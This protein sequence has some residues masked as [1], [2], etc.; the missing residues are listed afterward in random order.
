[1]R[2]RQLTLT[3]VLLA[4]LFAS[5]V[6]AQCEVDQVFPTIVAGPDGKF[7]QS[8]A[9][10]DDTA[11]VGAPFD[12]SPGV[13]T[14]SVA[15]FERLT[16]AGWTPADL[17]V[18]ADL[19]P[20]DNFGFAVAL[21]DNLAAVGSWSEDQLGTDAGAVYIFE[22]VAGSW[23][24]TVKLFA[25]DTG[26]GSRFG[27]SV[28]LEG[29]TLLVGSPGAVGA[30]L[31]PS[32]GS[33][34]VFERSG[35]GLW[36]Q[37]AKL[38]APDGASGD[39][40]GTS[41]ALSLPRALVGAPGHAAS[42]PASGAAYVSVQPFPGSWVPSAKLVAGDGNAFDQFGS[43]VALDADLAGVGAPGDSDVCSSCGAAY[44][45]ANSGPG[46]WTQ[47]HKAGG[48]PI[49]TELTGGD[50]FGAAVAIRGTTAAVG[51]PG[52]IDA[53]FASGSVYVYKQSAD[54]SYVKTNKLNACDSVSDDLFGTSLAMHSGTLIIGAP[55]VDALGPNSG[56]VYFFSPDV[57]EFE[58][59][60]ITFLFSE[61]GPLGTVPADG[62]SGGDAS[63]DD[64]PGFPL[65]QIEDQ[66]DDDPDF[67]G[68]R[69]IHRG[70]LWE[71]G[72]IEHPIPSRF[73]YD[74]YDVTQA[75]EIYHAT[76]ADCD[77]S[78][79]FDIEDNY[80]DPVTGLTGKL[81]TFTWSN[82]QADNDGM[83]LGPF[84]VVVNIFLASNTTF[85]RFDL[86]ATATGVVPS[87]WAFWYGRINL[88]I[89]EEHP[90]PPEEDLDYFLLTPFGHLVKN[91]ALN[92]IGDSGQNIPTIADALG[93]PANQALGM[94]D[95]EGR[96]LYAATLDDTGQRVKNFQF[97]GCPG[98]GSEEPVV[99][100]SALS[101]QEDVSPDVPFQ[102]ISSA[103]GRF[104]GDWYTLADTYRSWLDGGALF[105]HKGN[106]SDRDDVPD[107]AKGFQQVGVL[108]FGLSKYANPPR[109]VL[110][111]PP[112]GSAAGI[113]SLSV[114]KRTGL[115]Y[116]PLPERLEQYM[117]F[118]GL[119]SLVV[120]QFGT[121]W[122]DGVC[123]GVGEYS[124]T[125]MFEQNALAMQAKEDELSLAGRTLKFLLYFLDSRYTTAGTSLDWEDLAIRNPAGDTLDTFCPEGTKLVLMDPSTSEWQAHMSS[126]SEALGELGV[127]GIYCD[128]AFPELRQYDFTDDKGHAP[129]FG[130]YMTDGFGRMFVEIQDGGGKGNP[131]P[132]PDFMTYT[133]FFFEGFIP[134]SDTY[135]P[136]QAWTDWMT[137]DGN[138]TQV[139]LL[140]VLYH[141]YTILG[142]PFAGY[143]THD[144]PP[145]NYPNNVLNLGDDAERVKGRSGAN[146]TMAYGWVNG[147]P[148]WSPD[149]A[150]TNP[151]IKEY[152]Y[153]LVESNYGLPAG[154]F[155]EL[156]A[157]CAFGAELARVRGFTEAAPFL[158]TGRRVRDLADFATTPATK[159][160]V[161][162][163]IYNPYAPTTN[164]GPETEAFPTTLH[165]VWSDDDSGYVGIA[166]ANYTDASSSANFTFDPAAYGF[167]G[168]VSAYTVDAGGETL[169]TGPF[170]EPTAF[171]LTLPAESTLF[172]R[173]RP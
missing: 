129:G 41:V 84:E 76:G 154:T 61:P 79:D 63:C 159:D 53:G 40:Y 5:P 9:I 104:R 24:E 167:G 160:V 73:D 8:V 15:V 56:A 136:E 157:V 2:R 46:T 19:D 162:M 144:L 34:Y 67:N 32:A 110:A 25:L 83:T 55:D 122:V 143:Y 52:N 116:G 124:I 72:V 165:G 111:P 88:A 36:S 120:A 70:Q 54:L 20:G 114:D 82:C 47:T 16:V 161:L 164:L 147:C 95:E 118:W 150:L 109:T 119:D 13:G 17:L 65:I 33:A 94:Y 51:A 29:T 81:V 107:F 169:L 50:R 22:R 141:H 77:A 134:E 172:V 93:R 4:S 74:G 18:P 166:L 103:V 140:S 139:P 138:T 127:D 86:S 125:P 6:L 30:G 151:R 148:I 132:G 130:S 117:D 145:F 12:V 131:S 126:V 39:L 3:S 168:S 43:A 59:D 44:L 64:Q 146:Y 71:I 38:G 133:E 87:D 58:N 170:S 135:G 108:D 31:T 92:L 115:N 75:D 14:G 171:D 155:D 28:A 97:Y 68:H 89:E 37:I 91:P 96:G 90:D 11:L 42:G 156:R 10:W 85:A 100:I 80:L 173:I 121:Q 149:P 23:F 1:M 106:V 158:T 101:Y 113:A 152:S 21:S 105:T 123:S 163:E 142:P 26:P 153:E 78:V 99:N 112:L 35:P 102:S 98:D 27:Y 62:S 128:N 49:A 45:F 60:Q 57:I 7:G 66:L 48:G 69:F 137:A